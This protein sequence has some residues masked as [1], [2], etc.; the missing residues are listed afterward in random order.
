MLCAAG[1]DLEALDTD[2]GKG[3]LTDIL[4]YHVVAGEVPSSAVTDGLVVPSTETISPSQSA[5]Q[6]WSTTQPSF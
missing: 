5:T 4:L 3:A 6:S 1:I 2:E